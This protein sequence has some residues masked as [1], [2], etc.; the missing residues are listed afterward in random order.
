MNRQQRAEALAKALSMIGT[1]KERCPTCH[2]P[3]GQVIHGHQPHS[4]YSAARTCGIDPQYVYR[5]LKAKQPA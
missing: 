1:E 3:P 5:A 2:R 4:P